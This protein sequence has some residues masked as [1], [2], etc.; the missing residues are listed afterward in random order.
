[1]TP[2][3]RLSLSLSLTLFVWGP[4]AI[5]EFGKGT[6]NLAH[7]LLRFVVTFAF[8]RVAVWGVGML[9]DTYRASVLSERG[10][11]VSAAAA[12]ASVVGDRRQ[13]SD[14]DLSSSGGG[15]ASS[16]PS[17]LRNSVGP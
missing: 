11:V 7:L 6:L 5:D 16:I 3:L 4:N 12:S 17:G 1:M 8:F 10:T 9:L 14:P 2:F 13:L 15:A